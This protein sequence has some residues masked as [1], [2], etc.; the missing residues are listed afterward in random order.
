[1]ETIISFFKTYLIGRFLWLLISL[2]TFIT[3][4]PIIGNTGVNSLFFN[5][6]FA[7]MLIAGVYTVS[8]NTHLFIIMCIL[9]FTTI[10]LEVASLT[11][12][13]WQFHQYTYY[14]GITFFGFNACAILR[15]VFHGTTVTLDKI[16][17]AVAVYFLV[18]L[19]FSFIFAI[20]EFKHTGAFSNENIQIKNF[21]DIMPSFIYYSFVTLTTLGYGDIT[22]IT[23]AAKTA[24]YLE[25]CL[26]Q[27]FMV[28][29]MARLVGFHVAQQSSN[30]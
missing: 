13:N 30:N 12:E 27:I 6:I 17:G 1:M 11:I 18:G 2:L 25:A 21:F 7:A 24:S 22:P 16:Y 20:I 19:T 14:A 3:L 9:A 10:S 5:I 8:H 4:S 26:G 29:L 23:E 15:E 28:V